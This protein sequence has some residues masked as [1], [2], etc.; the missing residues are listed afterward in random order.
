MSLI[1]QL[2]NQFY[3][4]PLFK[5]F[6]KNYAKVNGLEVVSPR[7]I[8]NRM[9]KQ[10]ETQ[11]N[12]QLPE[13]VEQEVEK[14]KSLQQALKKKEAMRYRMPFSFNQYVNPDRKPWADV[15]FSYLRR[16][17][18]LYPIARACINRRKTQITQLGWSITPLDDDMESEKFSKEIGLVQ[19]WLKHPMGHKTRFRE[20]ISLIVEDTLVIDA[21]CYELRKTQKGDFINLIPVDPTTI[22]LRV[23]STGGTPEPP[24]PAYVQVIQGQKVAAFTTDEMLYEFM[25]P[26]SY[27]PYGKAPLESLILQVESA[28]RGTL[29]NLNY[30]RENNV[31]EGFLTLPE[32]VASDRDQIEQWQEWFDSIMA[33]NMRTVHRL[34]VLPNGSEYVPA[35]K[36]EDMAFERFELWLLQQ[37][38]AVFDVPPQDIGI[39]YQVNKA[40]GE[41]Q[42]DLSNERGLI[43]L[44][45][46]IKEIM[47]DLIHNEFGFE[48]IQFTWTNINP[49]DR[50]EEI[51]I[52]EKEIKLGALSVDEYRKREGREP[53]GLGHYIMTGMGVQLVDN[54]LNPPKEEPREDEDKMDD[55]KQEKLNREEDLKKW[56]KMIFNDLY[57]KRPQFRTF[58]TD[59]IDEATY[60][61]I[62]TGLKQVKTKSDVEQLFNHYMNPNIRLTLKL[63]EVSEEMRRLEHAEIYPI[64]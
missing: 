36:P 26:R 38:C 17:A 18:E 34:K 57:R 52:A 32:E 54:V 7:I 30:L 1:S 64:D 6:I 41:T 29:F 46:F 55:K 56:R 51:D 9:S 5:G 45:N 48:R 31:P 28:L 25:S 23:T 2:S 59:Y 49:V 50:K 22:V 3:K 16:M 4:T 15:P 42:K 20:L 19:E 61:L 44:G 40:T 39:T 37:T 8:R 63:M 58:R 14:A 12:K 13:L 27:N 33:G 11:V 43:P 47:D 60:K 21:V 35:K 53:I 62:N 24:D 10:V